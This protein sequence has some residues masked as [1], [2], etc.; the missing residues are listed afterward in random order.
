MIARIW[1]G[2]TRPE[3]AEAYAEYLRE[4]GMREYRSTPGNVG[5]YMLRRIVGDRAEWITLTLWDS[6]EAIERFSGEDAE[7]AVYYPEDRHYLI[8]KDDRA[9]HWEVLDTDG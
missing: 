3:D 4:T 6:I 8:D 7:R 9:T 1:R 2:A 5:V